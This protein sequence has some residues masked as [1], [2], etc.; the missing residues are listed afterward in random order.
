MMLFTRSTYRNAYASGTGDR[1]IVS[2]SVAS[3]KWN[4]PY[5]VTQVDTNVLWTDF[6][7]FG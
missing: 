5:L 7:I 1:G 6:I 3:V 2:V 4:A